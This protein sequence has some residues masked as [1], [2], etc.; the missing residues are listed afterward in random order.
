MQ[1]ETV[2]VWHA[3]G[4]A[5]EPPPFRPTFDHRCAQVTPVAKKDA[6]RRQQISHV[7]SPG[8]AAHNQQH[9]PGIRPVLQK[10]HRLDAQPKPQASHDL[11]RHG[12][13]IPAQG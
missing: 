2:R 9:Q 8:R 6:E 1:T 12:A 11:L 10:V 3:R 5:R 4:Y 7:Q 13:R